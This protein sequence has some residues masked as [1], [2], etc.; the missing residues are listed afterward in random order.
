MAC[1]TSNTRVKSFFI[2]TEDANVVFSVVN[3]FGDIIE[4]AQVS[5]DCGFDLLNETTDKTGCVF[6]DLVPDIICDLTVEKECYQLYREKVTVKSII[7]F[8]AQKNFPFQ[9]LSNS[10]QVITTPTAEIQYISKNVVNG[11][12]TATVED[13]QLLNTNVNGIYEAEFR[14]GLQHR[15]II[16]GGSDGAYDKTIETFLKVDCEETAFRLIPM[17]QLT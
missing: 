8:D 5:I 10:G 16:N 2:A 7:N 13:T 1:T 14:F 9:I 12:E 15:L 6:F 4:D 17:I 11:M 3:V